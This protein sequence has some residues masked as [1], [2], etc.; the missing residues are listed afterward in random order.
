V[1]A[2]ALS[3]IGWL[4]RIAMALHAQSSEVSAA[5]VAQ[6]W[7]LEED[8]LKPEVRKSVDRVGQLL[9]DEFIEFGSSGRVFNK[10]K[11]IVALQQEACD[12]VHRISLTDFTVRRLA[13]DVMLVTYRT[14]IQDPPES[15]L[16]SSIWKLISGRWQM[17][18][19]QGTPSKAANG[20]TAPRCPE[21]LACPRD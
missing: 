16:R 4:D 9:A 3:A 2:V 1:V 11:I 12:A 8:L 15:S 7:A 6:L 10:A 5:E 18:F 21:P 17:V 20:G 13:P 19:H 14:T